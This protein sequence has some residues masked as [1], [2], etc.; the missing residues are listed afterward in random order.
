MIP[1]LE[2]AARLLELRNR[3]DR[4]P[5]HIEHL[6]LPSL[7]ANEARFDDLGLNLGDIAEAHLPRRSGGR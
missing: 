5:R 1:H 3:S 2:L 4:R 7:F 6:P